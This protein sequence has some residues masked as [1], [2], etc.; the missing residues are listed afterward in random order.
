MANTFCDLPIELQVEI[1]SNLDAVS[2]I[3][4]AMVSL[5]RFDLWKK[6]N[7][8]ITQTC[9]SIYET[10]QG[11]SLLAYTIELHR[12]GLKDAGTSLD[13]PDLIEALRRRRQD[14]LSLEMKKPLTHLTQH[15]CHAF[16]LVGGAYADISEDRFEMRRLP[17]ASN[18]KAHAFQRSSIGI[19][20]AN[21][22]MDPTQ[23]LMVILEEGGA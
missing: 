18:A 14:W 4:C 6:L 1:L 13:Y 9:T 8:R 10:F 21:F 20:A 19:S 3:R 2:L 5:R 12:D 23:D 7:N 22:S 15:N 17:T 11:S 16:E